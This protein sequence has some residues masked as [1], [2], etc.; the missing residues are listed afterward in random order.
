MKENKINVIVPFYNCKKFLEGCVSSVMTQKYSNFHVYFIDDC[1]SDGG[2]NLLPHEDKRATCIKNDINKTALP[3]IHNT[4]ME[5]CEKDSIIVLLDG[6]DRLLKKTVLSTVNDLYNEHNCW[7]L[8]G[9]SLWSDG[10]RGFA[11]AYTKDEFEHLRKTYF[12]VSHL[13][14]FIAGVYHKIKEQDENFSIFKDKNGEFYRSC[15][16]VPIVWSIM[17][18]SG[19]DKIYFN[20]IPLYLYNRDNPLNDDKVNQQLQWDIHKEI[21]DK[22]PFKKIESY[23]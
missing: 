19:Y 13:R 18:L 7:F 8:Y 10:R 5:Y 1:S 6:D 4:I 22:N 20:D 9:Q 14:S 21:S 17:E 15:Y 16:D 23:E 2:W 3:N 11:S 12:K